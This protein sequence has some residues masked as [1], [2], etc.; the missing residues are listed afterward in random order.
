M[1]NILLGSGTRIDNS[2]VITYFK[3]IEDIKANTCYNTYYRPEISVPTI[4]ICNYFKD[5][6][7][8]CNMSSC[9]F[10]QVINGKTE[11]FYLPL[12]CWFYGTMEEVINHLEDRNK[13]IYLH[14]VEHYKNN[15]NLYI[16]EIDNR[17]NVRNNKLDLI[18]G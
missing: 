6:I 11:M 5:R 17:Y 9:R 18:L 3:K 1:D 16:Y 4:E 13:I 14:N 8:Y 15:W 2:Y 10:C 12:N 7:K